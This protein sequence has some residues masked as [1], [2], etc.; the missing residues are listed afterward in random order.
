M[1]PSHGY[2][3]QQRRLTAKKS[4]SKENSKQKKHHSKEVSQPRSLTANFFA[5]MFFLL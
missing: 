2:S 5:V 3:K 1:F 4:H